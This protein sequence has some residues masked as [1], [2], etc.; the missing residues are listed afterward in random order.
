[1]DGD[2]AHSNLMPGVIPEEGDG[3]R[4]QTTAGELLRLPRTLG[5]QL[6]AT[7][8]DGAQRLPTLGRAEMVVVVAVVVGERARWPLLP[9]YRRRRE[10]RMPR[11]TLAHGLRIRSLHSKARIYGRDKMQPV[12]THGYYVFDGD[13]CPKTYL[14]ARLQAF[15]VILCCSRTRTPWLTRIP[16][17]QV[18]QQRSDQDGI[19]LN[20]RSSANTPS[21]RRP[22]SHP[23][24]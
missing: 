5:V 8:A 17:Q 7:P 18:R 21:P 2:R 15:P 23:R 14:P 20:S 4:P 24:L 3:E 16:I 6:L 13:L 1:M 19:T 9:Q 12:S 22:C 11:T 10:R